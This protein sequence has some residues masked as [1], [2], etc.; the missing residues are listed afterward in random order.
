[1]Q[2]GVAGLTAHVLKVTLWG[3]S[4]VERMG[5]VV[6]IC[7]CAVWCSGI[8]CTCTEGDIIGTVSGREGGLSYVY[9]YVCSLV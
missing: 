8:N 9:T 3:L 5:L 1:V 6:S 4:V 2:F 7:M